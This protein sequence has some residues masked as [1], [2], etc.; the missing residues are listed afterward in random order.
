MFTLPNPSQLRATAPSFKIDV[1]KQR[2]VIAELQ[3]GDKDSK[4]GDKTRRKRRK[5][6]EKR[7]GRRK[8][9]MFFFI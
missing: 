4:E 8:R 9:S 7:E 2:E 3:R 1:T 5:E 6:G